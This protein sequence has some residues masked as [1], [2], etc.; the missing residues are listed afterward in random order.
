MDECIDSLSDPQYLSTLNVSKG[1]CQLAFDPQEYEKTAFVTHGGLYEWQR[2]PFR[3]VNAPATFQRALDINRLNYKRKIC[4]VY[5][6][7]V[8]IFPML[9]KTTFPE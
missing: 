2:M 1:F 3:L 6:D 4:L 8:V 5:I 7:D 9:L